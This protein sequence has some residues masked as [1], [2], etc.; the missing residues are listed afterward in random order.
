MTSQCKVCLNN[1]PAMNF[2][3]PDGEYR[4]T[5]CWRGYKLVTRP[6][7]RMIY[8]YAQL[9][10]EALEASRSEPGDFIKVGES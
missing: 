9:T 5:G 3:A 10:K 2:D 6:G 8:W 1:G 7:W 4:C